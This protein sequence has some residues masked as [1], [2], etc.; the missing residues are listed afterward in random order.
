MKN[1][2]KIFPHVQVFRAISVLLVFCYHLKLSFF[3]NG[4]LGVDI[5]FVISGFVITNT[6]Y[7]EFKEKNKINFLNFYKKR[8]KRI[9]PVLF[10]ILTFVYIFYKFYG[11]PEISIGKDYLYSILGVPNLFYL[12]QNINYFNNV[13]DNPLGHTWSLGIEEQFYIIYPL[14][15][16]ILFKNFT[17][18]KISLTFYFVIFSSIVIISF[19]NLNNNTIFYNPI[20]RFW[21]FFLGCCIPFLKVKRNNYLSLVFFLFIFIILSLNIFGEGNSNTNLY[22]FKNILITISASLFLIFYNKPKKILFIFENKFF[23]LL[24]NLSYSIYLWHLPVIYFSNI[25][26]NGINFFLISLFVTLTLSYFTFNFIENFFRYKIWDIRLFSKIFLLSIFLFLLFFLSKNIYSIEDLR[27]FFKKNNYLEKNL[28]WIERTTFRQMKINNNSVYPNCQNNNK[29]FN[30]IYNLNL[31]CYKNNNSKVLFFLKGNSFIAQHIP[32]FNN[33]KTNHDLYYDHDNTNLEIDYELL[34]NLKVRYDKIYIVKSINTN[35]E[36]NYFI[37][38]LNENKQ[39]KKISYFLI[40]PI[41]NFKDKYLNPLTCLI[42]KL[43]CKITKYQDL[44]ERSILETNFLIKSL[45]NNNKNVIFFDIYKVLCPLKI[46]SVYDKKEN[47]LMLRDKSHLSYESSL[48]VSNKFNE[49]VKR[50]N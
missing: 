22:I 19:I 29:K 50:L 41:P 21:E 10:F 47:F 40:G 26:F 1:N 27:V 46:C 42:Q 28:N 15:L 33:L 16:F 44:K 8:F 23:V 35:D 32:M 36:L 3:E 37:N 9:F 25:Y 18:N 24:G 30:N 45:M 2:L 49:F 48:S 20:F 6:L 17:E 5:F 12:V 13:F 43:S 4:Y 11:P 14:L 34:D 38:Y 31:K 39:S 7:A